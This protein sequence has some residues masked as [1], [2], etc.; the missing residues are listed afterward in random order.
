MAQT[1]IILSLRKHES[2]FMNNDLLE[3]IEKEMECGVII[4]V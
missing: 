2:L 4:N 1:K 3:R